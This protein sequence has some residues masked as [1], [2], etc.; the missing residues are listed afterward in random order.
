MKD[1][2]LDLEGFDDPTSIETSQVSVNLIIFFNSSLM[3]SGK[4]NSC[5]ATGYT[6]LRVG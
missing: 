4:I 1:V 6:F 5:V 3:I 2:G